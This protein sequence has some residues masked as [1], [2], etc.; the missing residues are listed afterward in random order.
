MNKR[1]KIIQ[2]TK[3]IL[4]NNEL[5]HAQ[6]DGWTALPET[7]KSAPDFF[8]V[9]AYKEIIEPSEQSLDNAQAEWNVRKPPVVKRLLPNSLLPN[10]IE[11]SY[12][13]NCPNCR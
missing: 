4:F 6:S 2:S 8:S 7:L 5:A 12:D 3:S 9:L 11:H 13:C 1:Y 10:S